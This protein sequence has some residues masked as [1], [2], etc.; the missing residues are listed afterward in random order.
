MK[1][2]MFGHKRIPS[3]EGGIEIVVEELAA[4]MAG[5]GH[6]VTCYNRG[7]HH[8]SGAQFDSTCADELRKV[9]LKTVWTLDKKGL[10]AVTSSICAAFRSAFSKADVV[11]IHAEGPAVMC[12]LPRL[13]GKKVV[14]TVHGLDWQREKWK[15]GF[16]ARYIHLGEKMAVRFADEIIVLSRNVQ[17]YFADTYGR[18]TVMIPNGVAKPEIREAREI[19]GRYG[20]HKDEY[21][22]FLGRLVPEKGVHY[23][24]EAF[25]KVKTDK[26]LVIAGG[27][28]DSGDYEQ[29][30]REMAAGNGN[31]LFTGFIQ[32]QLLEELYS[33]AYLYVLPSDV[34]GMPLSLLEAMS[35]QNCCLT[36]DIP[37]CTE[38]TEDHGA[39]FRRGEIEDLAQK[40][41]QLCDEPE[42][43]R[44]YKG[45]ACDFI[46]GKYN[47]D[48]VTEK[49]LDLYGWKR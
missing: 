31:I 22:L 7:G 9:R 10:A 19:T 15:G 11:H 40:L 33:N 27:S 26:K 48:A 42:T 36:S 1:I 41:Q 8:V 21:I 12:W 3:R 46:C 47:W 17:Q 14:V 45:T 13:F 25:R 6:E 4:R 44:E 28:S 16:G 38:V 35:Y 5:L 37:E 24:I 32:G 2:V 18:R 39:A 20:L 43:V 49:T 29:K 23:L 30:L 34:E